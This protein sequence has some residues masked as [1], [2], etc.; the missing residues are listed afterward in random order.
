MC[1]IVGYVGE[2]QC[3]ELL[4]TDAVSDPPVQLDDPGPDHVPV[5]SVRA[6]EVGDADHEVIDPHARREH[7]DPPG[8]RTA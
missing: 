3:K 1:G 6:R 5:E 2:R 8:R 7:T 4:L